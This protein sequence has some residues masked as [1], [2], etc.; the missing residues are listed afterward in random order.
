M[1]NIEKIRSRDLK[2]L[3]FDTETIKDSDGS[4]KAILISVY[5][6][7]QNYFFF[8]I[9]DFVNFIF[10][11]KYRN[12]RFFS[13]NLEFD[14]CSSIYKVA[15]ELKLTCKIYYNKSNLIKIVVCDKNNNRVT[16]CDSMNFFRFSI[17]TLGQALGL[18]KLQKPAFLGCKPKNKE[19]WEQLKKY[20]ARD[21]E[22]IYRA[23][24]NLSATIT[25]IKNTI[26]SSA[27]NQLKSEN[28]KIKE[29]CSL[30]IAKNQFFKNAYFGGRVES[31]WRG[32]VPNV[33]CY[34]FNSLYPYVLTFKYPDLNSIRE[35]TDI[36]F[37]KLGIAKVKVKVDNV[38]YPILPIKTEKLIFATGTFEGTWTFQE[39]AFLEE[40]K[41]GRVEQ[42]IKAYQ[43]NNSEYYYRDFILKHYE[44]RLKYKQEKNPL[45]LN[46]KLLMNSC[47]GKLGEYPERTE[48]LYSNNKK[49]SYKAINKG[50]SYLDFNQNFLYRRI[51]NKTTTNTNFIHSSFVTAYARLELAK[52]VLEILKHKG[53]VFYTDTDSIFTNRELEENKKLGGLKLEKTGNAVFIKAKLYFMDNKLTAKGI[54]RTAKE[55]IKINFGKETITTG[56]KRFVRLRESLRRIDKGAF[57]QEQRI[58]KATLTT[59]SKRIYLENLNAKELFEKNTDSKPINL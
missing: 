31:L 22:I 4:Q 39:L 20:C 28:S 7:I 46:E 37:N 3:C 40:Q 30:K 54:E 41:L 32:Y 26:S 34:D 35:V 48:L 5:D 29:F 53:K 1:D 8:S 59:D 45:E 42:I 21:S 14:F 13:H 17:E 19:E 10:Q 6:G 49:E 18:P 36:N 16:F 2:I 47:Y 58:Y 43:F 11:K 27:F 25:K 56:Y 55:Q 44:Q 51:E 23:L 15:K 57:E 50:F 38:Y 12:Y 9:Y 24:Q 33:K 52:K